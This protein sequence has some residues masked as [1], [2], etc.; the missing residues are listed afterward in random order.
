MSTL[1]L[2]VLHARRGGKRPGARCASAGTVN[3]FQARATTQAA[4]P[5][6]LRRKPSKHA[7]AV[8]QPLAMG[9]C[10]LRTLP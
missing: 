3:L 10:H 4:A 1:N 5:R 7:K 8:L 2:L 9:G 6:L